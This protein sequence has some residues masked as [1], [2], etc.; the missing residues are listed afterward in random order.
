MTDIA[1]IDSF[2][3]NGRLKLRPGVTKAKVAKVKALQEAALAGDMVADAILQETISSSDAIFNAAW[4]ANLQFI[5]QFLELPRTWSQ[6][7]DIK[8][9]D[10]F[11]PIILRGLFG[12]FEGLERGGSGASTTTG[13]ANPAGIAPVVAELE[14]YPYATIGE[15]ESAYG[16]LNKRGFKVG[17]SWESQFKRGAAA[18]FAELPTEMLGVALDTEEWEVYNA[19]VVGTDSG[20]Q[21]AAGTTFT[22]AAVLANATVSRNAILLA[23]Q[24]LAMRQVNG[25]YVGRSANGYNVIVPIGAGPS[26]QFML[27]QQIISNQ[28]GSF[29]LSV[30]DQ[31][32][33]GAVTVVE[34]QY[35]T[36][37]NWYLLA[38]PGGY[39]RPVLSL[40]RLRG[41]EVPDLRV[42]NAVGT[43][44]GGARVSPFEGSFDNDS[45]DLRLR[46]AISGILWDDDLVVWSQGDNVA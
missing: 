18:F 22:G 1:T 7:A 30:Q 25:R 5:P 9:V 15:A 29:T 43:F 31:A 27:N 26:V 39:R 44:V 28:D 3:A 14:S 8:P 13:P 36:G 16:R 20:S 32:D 23:I 11:D 40:G 2:T 10:D 45:V 33:L 46:I 35:V 38:K 17:R 24:Q 12:E 42:E 41:H 37:T 19:L 34:T 6:V 21:L 4:L